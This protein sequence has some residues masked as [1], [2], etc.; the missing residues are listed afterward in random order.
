MWMLL[1]LVLV[2]VVVVGANDVGG[3]FSRRDICL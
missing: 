1:L 2:E 3:Q